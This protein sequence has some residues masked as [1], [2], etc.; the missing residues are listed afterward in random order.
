MS[1]LD[2]LK[3]SIQFINDFHKHRPRIAITLGSGLSGFVKSVKVGATIPYQDIPHFT[4]STVDGHP[5]NL[6][7]GFVENVPV[8]VLQGRIHYYE[9]HPMERVVYPTRV[10]AQLGIEKLI[11]TN[12]A[13]GLDTNMRAGDLMVIRDHINLTGTNPLIGP[14]VSA[15]GL[16]FPDMSAAYDHEMIGQ[17]TQI[18]KKN[19]I[20]HSIGVYCG[21]SGPTYE[22]AAEVK[23]LQHIGGHAVGMSTVPETIAAKH[24]GLR[25]F[26][27]SCI[28]NM[29]T[30]LSPDGG[31]ITHEE[32]SATAARVE[33]SFTTFL[34]EFISGL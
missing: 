5:G 15:L 19:N 21:V 33:T 27:I 3:E 18:L 26:G 20:R 32:V 28:S 12:A 30:G 9:G 10:V 16:R 34:S 31:S 25:V 8:V 6:I 13:G 23:Y 14:N 7:L 4:P 24:L 17:A 29:A 11:L 1:L 22:T 2:Q